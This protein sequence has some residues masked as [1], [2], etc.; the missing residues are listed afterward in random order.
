[1]NK[2]ISISQNLHEKLGGV[3]NAS[4]LISQLLT[5]HF[6]VPVAVSPENVEF[7]EAEAIKLT[8]RATALEKEAK[9]MRLVNELNLPA[10]VII[11]IK[12][13]LK[14]NHPDK[15]FYLSEWL[16]FKRAHKLETD[17]SIVE[18]AWGI[19]SE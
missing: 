19:L 15:T 12:Q 14:W 16:P 11:W 17:S 5:E 13:R 4:A 2:T 3:K 18:K 7:I 8:D 6:A 9:K 1:M 10:E